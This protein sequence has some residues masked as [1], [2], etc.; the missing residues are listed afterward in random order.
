MKTRR[1]FYTSSN[2]PVIFTTQRIFTPENMSVLAFIFFVYSLA[3]SHSLR[4]ASL[5]K[6]LRMGVS[7]QCFGRYSGYPSSRLPDNMRMCDLIKIDYT[8]SLE[9][10]RSISDDGQELLNLFVD[11]IYNLIWRDD[12]S[13]QLF[14]MINI[15]LGSFGNKRKW[16][17]CNFR[18]FV[19]SN[20]ILVSRKVFLTEL[21]S[22]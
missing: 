14:I 1:L 12:G 10:V 8:M 2:K 9:F 13:C 19:N 4:Y 18:T 17:L 11:T 22:F 20:R 7:T 5:L 3:L 6:P 16:H 21:N 15:V